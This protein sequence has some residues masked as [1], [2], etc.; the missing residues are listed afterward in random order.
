MLELTPEQREIRALAREFAQGEI[1]PHAA[2]WD[3]RRALDPGVFARLGELGF[4]GMMV[5]EAYGGLGLDLVT[6]LLALEELSWGD[7]GVA[8]GVA[9][10]SGPVTSLLLRHGTEEQKRRWLPALAGGEVLGAF[11]LSEAGAGSDAGALSTSWQRE[12]SGF[13]LEGRKKW[14]TNGGLAGLVVTFARSRADGGMSAFLVQPGSTGYRVARRE[15]TMGLSATETVEVEMAALRLGGD[16]LLGEEGAGFRYA[17]EALDIGRLGIAAQALGIARA[18]FEHAR[19]YAGQRVQFGRPLTRFQATRFKLAEMALRITRGR[20]LLQ[21]AAR[22]LQPAATGGQES[23]N[24]RRPAAD[25]EAF[26]VSALSAMAKVTASEDAIW[27]ADEAVQIFGGYGYMR[28][29]P[30]EKLLRDAKGT[31]IYEGTSEI[32]R[33][34][35]ARAVLGDKGA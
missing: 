24:A 34:V 11:A 30:V 8:L 35:V 15:V 16:A 2:L 13:V 9:I 28:D 26:S 31:E 3:S 1:R 29:Y 14:V 17:L 4:M 6:Y 32:M 5:P 25:P 10:H 21:A 19:E 23:G 12:E 27:I 7:A 18:A 22:V 33:L 20:A